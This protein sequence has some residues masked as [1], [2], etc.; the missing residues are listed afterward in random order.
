[1]MGIWQFIHVAQADQQLIL[2]QTVNFGLQTTITL[3]G[4][5]LGIAMPNV[6]DR[7]YTDRTSFI[8]N[9]RT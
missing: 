7:F 9:V 3:I 1:M 4:I 2:T 6:I 8:R 5:A